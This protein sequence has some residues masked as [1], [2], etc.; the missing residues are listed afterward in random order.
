MSRRRPPQE[1]SGRRQRFLSPRFELNS[2]ER[3]TQSVAKGIADFFSSR[4]PP[5]SGGQAFAVCRT[6]RHRARQVLA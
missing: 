2:R 3:E 5:L 6:D 1:W 4:S